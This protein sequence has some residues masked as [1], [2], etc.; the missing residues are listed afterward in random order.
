MILSINFGF[1][2]NLDLADKRIHKFFIKLFN[3]SA[4]SNDF[5]ECF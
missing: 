3:I 1:P 2:E 4:L 5:K